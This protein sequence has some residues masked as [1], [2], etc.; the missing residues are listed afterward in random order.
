MELNRATALI[1]TLQTGTPMQL[2]HSFCRIVFRSSAWRSDDA[3]YRGARHASSF[4]E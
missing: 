1:L 3:D 2:G 4:A